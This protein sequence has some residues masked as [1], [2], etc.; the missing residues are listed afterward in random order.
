MTCGAIALCGLS[1][2]P[3]TSADS[4]TQPGGVLPTS[5]A[6]K[7]ADVKSSA[8]KGPAYDWQAMGHDGSHDAHENDPN[9]TV[10]IAPT[11]GVNW[12][13]NLLSAYLGGP[14]IA[15]NPTVGATL[16]YTGDERGNVAAYSEATGQTVWS[17]S[18]AAGDAIYSTPLVTRDE[19][20]VWVGT[21]F[22][23]GVWK[24]NAATGAIDC[25]VKTQLA[26]QMS[27][28]EGKSSSGTPMVYAGSIDGGKIAGPE[29]GLAES[30]CAVI[31]SSNPYKVPYTGS[32]ASPA[33][34]IDVNGRRLIFQ[35]TADPD[36]SEYAIDATTG[37]LDWYFATGLIGD[38]DIG[39]AA[40]VS[41]PGKN[42]FTDGVLYVI[43]K[44]Q[45]AY[46]LNLT[47]G[48]LI[49]EFDFGKDSGAPG[50]NA[51]SAAALAGN[52]IVFG[53]ANGV[54][55][56][57]A[58]TGAVV[59]HY[60]DPEQ[61]EVMSNPAVVGPPGKEVVAFGDLAGQF[62][63][64]NFATGASL[65]Q[66]QTGN[67]ITASPSYINGHFL[68]ASTDG[69]LYDFAAGGGNAAAPSTGISFPSQGSNQ[70]YSSTITIQGTATDAVGVNA[71]QVAVQSGGAAGTWYD[72]ATK[73]WGLGAM[74][75]LVAVAKPGSKSSTWTCTV[76]VP[77][78]GAT[79]RVFANAVNVSQ[80]ADRTGTQTSF[81]VAF[82]PSAPQLQSSPIFIVPAATF[83]VAGS[84]FQPKETVQFTIGSTVLGSTKASKTGT[85][86][87]SLALPAKSEFGPGAVTATGETSE[88]VA[89]GPIDIA[90]TWLQ[91]GSN[92]A[93]TAFEPNDLVFSNE[94]S[95]GNNNYLSMAW[96]FMAAAAVESSPS[97]YQAQIF[98][99]DDTGTLEAVQNDT[100]VPVWSITIPS[101]AAIRSTPAVD[102]STG[103]L[104]FTA[105]DGGVY[106]VTTATGAAVGNTTVGGL[107]TS[108][109]VNNG[110]IYVGSDNSTLSS[111]SEQSGTVNWTD[112][113]AGAIHATP[114]LDTAT[115]V[116]VTGDDSGAISAFNGATGGTLWQVTTGGPVTAAPVIANGIVYVGSS[117][118]N[119]YALK[120][121]SGAPVWTYAAG[122]AIA[123][124]AI[125]DPVL[126]LVYAGCANGTLYAVG[127]TSGKLAWSTFP[128]KIPLSPY[129]GI[130]AA[131]ALIF[132]DVASGTVVSFRS[133]QVGKWNSDHTTG[134]A[135]TTAPAV[136]D[137][138]VYVGA[139]DGG[140]YAY[141]TTGALPQIIPQSIRRAA[142]A[143]A[144]ERRQPV[145]RGAQQL[146]RRFSWT[147]Q[148]DF[149]LHVD[150][151]SHAP[152]NASTSLVYHG[153]PVQRAPHTYLVVWKPAGVTIE[154]RYVP[155]VTAALRAAKNGLAGA[156]VDTTPY[157]DQLSDAAM[158][159]EIAR[160]ITAN[161]WNA[162]IDSQ[163]LLLTAD[164]AL[165]AGAGFCSYHSAF[166]LG[167]DRSKTV[168]YAVVPYSGAVG[169][170]R[171]PTELR[172]SG[173]PAIDAASANLRRA[174]QE[175]TNDP[176]LNG[177]HDANGGELP[178]GF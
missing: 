4:A 59:W 77:P 117:D 28:T 116:L 136:N 125:Y 107:P 6:S 22:D 40:T 92:A 110:T 174:Q 2:A 76:P 55:A 142:A 87:A 60:I 120:E 85:V 114:A 62:H 84:G 162:G 14:T 137:G 89:I 29:L 36:S 41:A 132:A 104:T 95:P 74:T 24:L 26:V 53:M 134:D 63:V 64:V 33:Y 56:L 118:G 11:L 143:L 150:S 106:V 35:G 25:S 163:F 169:A 156:A 98:F 144:A 101:G 113:L 178:P 97:V 139:S 140:L 157:P 177:W 16:V 31:F 10:S 13:T 44:K 172:F 122:S 65:Y 102:P 159:S 158:Q 7:A 73:S 141:T 100:A 51:R 30:N 105:D 15:Y 152:R 43:D 86:A 52:T 91:F 145:W 67:Y 119:L 126:K 79:L 71:V 167:R 90:N 1:T 123:A 93:H 94:I 39:A 161:H 34:G 147:G 82:S 111:I 58:T 23:A 42:G 151:I 69:F 83:K 135:L 21:T 115:N 176:L 50:G 18:I 166:A 57:N 127:A 173:D 121:S 45:I 131:T 9:M 148:R 75:N 32:W 88:L 3:A 171:T 112:T 129:A 149:A 72:L 70:P 66:Y 80:Q 146:Y 164:G 160:A 153:G 108:P 155:A 99:G 154:K 81:T 38:Y 8:K 103:D 170:C 49:W 165:P 46:A 12:M 124:A 54:Y 61:V 20:S 48:A 109:A 130:S 68:I 47:T 19:S 128:L 96:Y 138:T 37:A 5:R 175:L 27:P 17:T 78:S 168:V 133:S